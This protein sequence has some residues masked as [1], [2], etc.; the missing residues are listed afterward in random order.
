MNKHLVCILLSVAVLQVVSA[1]KWEPA[2]HE[3]SLTFPDGSWALLPGKMID[4]GQILLSAV[5]SRRTRAI[6]LAKYE[7]APSIS[8]Q[9]DR[10]VKG[11]R[12]GFEQSGFRVLSSGY[13]NI[14][15]CVAY[16]FSGEAVANGKEVSTLR[17]SLC[18]SGQLYQLIADSVEGSPLNDKELLRILTSFQMRS[19]GPPVA[20]S[21]RDNSLAYQIGR[22]TGFLLILTLIVGI[23]VN[24]SR[25]RSRKQAQASA[26]Y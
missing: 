25:K 15:G 2:T 18:S 10:F 7:V 17:Y 9:D 26:L 21:Y 19:H 4:H 14:N 16:W 5:Q 22:V 24:Q 3:C 12:N 23:V 1:E 20:A 6:T 13:T 8:V 11:L